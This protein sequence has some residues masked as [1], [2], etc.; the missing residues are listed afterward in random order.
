MDD[1]N[2]IGTYVTGATIATMDILREVNDTEFD[3]IIDT[4]HN[5][6]VSAVTESTNY[7][8]PQHSKDSSIMP[9]NELFRSVSPPPPLITQMDLDSK[10][11]EDDIELGSN[12]TMGDIQDEETSVHSQEI[13][14]HDI[15]M[16]N[17]SPRRGSTLKAEG[18]VDN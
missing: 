12:G 1:N 13:N 10:K 2:S 9:G 11:N 18:T 16:S 7:D 17:S 14:S 4:D 5:T 3:Q 8:S 15:I 6:V